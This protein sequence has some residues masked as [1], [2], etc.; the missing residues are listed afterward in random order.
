MVGFFLFFIQGTLC[1][2]SLQTH[3]VKLRLFLLNGGSVRH[4]R[5]CLSRL[6]IPLTSLETKAYREKKESGKLFLLNSNRSRVFLATRINENREHGTNIPHLHLTFLKKKAGCILG[7]PWD[8]RIV[9]A[10][11][12]GTHG[13]VEVSM[14]WHP[15]CQLYKHSTNSSA[16]LLWYDRYERESTGAPYTSC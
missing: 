13:I 3:T 6:P 4:S 7:C 15:H 11:Q 16:W 8:T 5:P 1:K 12:P 2:T 9:F 10:F 14:S